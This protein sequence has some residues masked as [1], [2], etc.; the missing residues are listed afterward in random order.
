MPVQR[1][2]LVP[3][4][5]VQH[6]VDLDALFSGNFIGHGVE[7]GLEDLRIAVGDDEAHQLAGGGLDGSDD[8]SPEVAAMIALGGAAAAFDPAVPGARISLEAG[9][10]TKEDPGG[11]VG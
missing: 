7:E 3:T 6:E 8:V 9:F 5:I 1:G 4:G 2:G 10:V 11:G